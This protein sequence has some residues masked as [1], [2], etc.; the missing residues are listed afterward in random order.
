VASAECPSGFQDPSGLYW[1]WCRVD[2]LKVNTGL[3]ELYMN[4]NAIDDETVM[5]MLADVLK[6]NTVLTRTDFSGGPQS[7]IGNEGAAALPDA[8]GLQFEWKRGP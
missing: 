8:L 6:C 5:V 7:T 2:T 3:T 1:W 4:Y